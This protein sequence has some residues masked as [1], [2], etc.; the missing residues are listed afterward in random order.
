ML[1]HISSNFDI[2]EHVVARQSI[3]SA[4]QQLNSQDFFIE[5]LNSISAATLQIVISNEVQPLSQKKNEAPD[6]RYSALHSTL[7][8]VGRNGI[9]MEIW[10]LD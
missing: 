9:S 6:R 8:R 4:V 5:L 1:G 2:I 10:M 3:T 7:L